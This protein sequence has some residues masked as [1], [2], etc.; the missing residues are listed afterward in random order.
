MVLGIEWFVTLGRVTFDFDNRCVEFEHKG[1]KVVLRG[2]DDKPIQTIDEQKMRQTIQHAGELCMLQVLAVE[3]EEHSNNPQ[4]NTATDSP[5]SSD[6][7]QLVQ[8]YTPIFQDPVDLPPFR[9]GYDHQITLK[10]GSNPVNLRPYRYS[11]LQKDVIEKMTKELLEQGV[12]KH[13][14]S[15]F[16]SPMVLVKKKDG[17]WRMCIDYRS[18]NKSTVPDRFPIPLLEELLE[19]LYGTKKNSKI[20]LK[21]GYYQIRM[22]PTDTHKTAFRTHCGHYEFLVMPFGLTNAPS[23]FQNLMNTIFE[24]YL[25]KFVLVFFD[26]ILIYSPTWSAHLHHL[27]LVFQT[28]STHS[29]FAKLSKCAFGVTQIEYLG[30]VISDSGVATDPV[31]IKAVFEWPSPVNIKQLRGFLGLTGYYRRFIKDYGGLAKP[32]TQD[33]GGLAKPLTQLLKKD[34]FQ[35]STEAEK[36]FQELKQAVIKPPVLALPDFNSTFIIE[37]DAS[38]RG[39]GAVLMQHGHPIAFISK[40]LSPRNILLSTYERELLEVIHAVQKWSHYILDRHFII[41]T[42]QESLK[43]LLEHKLATPFQQKWISKLFGLDY[44]IQYKKGVENKVADALSRIQ[45]GE[46]L[47]MMF[48]SVDSELLDKI[49]AAWISDPI[50]QKVISKLQVNASSHSKY[51]WKDNEL[52][53]NNKL[54]IGNDASLRQQLLQWMHNSPQGGH[55]GITATLKRIQRLFYWT[56]LKND[57]QKYIRE[58][59]NCQKCKADLAASPGMLQP[60]PIPK[61]IWEDIAMDF[62]EGLPL[63]KGKNVILY[64]A[65]IGLYVEV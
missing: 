49:K 24:P 54:V 31:K 13:S 20:D 33:Y 56:K 51:Q 40:A 44:E 47:S 29:L 37:T 2:S 42:D 7:Q 50:L 46:L 35:W 6:I 28:L 60:L 26:D 1:R 36:A 65:R 43:Y 5:V 52:R 11:L 30:H 8:E 10:D 18:L 16:A 9:P 22:L 19:E 48:G 64:L 63:S 58:C 39:I 25:R 45:S 27:G 17:G 4:V 32:L 38:S 59:E 15:T 57:V 21:S 3:G 61:A 14:N 62:I 53:R 41:K 12:I 23:T 34:C 55:S